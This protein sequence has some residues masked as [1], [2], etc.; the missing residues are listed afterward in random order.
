MSAKPAPGEEPPTPAV[1]D[2]V[3]EERKRAEAAGSPLKE[4]LEPAPKAKGVDVDDVI[5][6]KKILDEE[7]R[8]LEE[9]EQAGKKSLA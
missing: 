2:K 9:R 6:G 4:K 5:E 7:E 3:M 8:G 1:E